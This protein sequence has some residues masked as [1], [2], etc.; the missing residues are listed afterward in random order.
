ML[1]PDPSTVSDL[2]NLT[3]DKE[4][5][6]YF[7]IVV[8]LFCISLSL[9]LLLGYNNSEMSL[10]TKVEKIIVVVKTADH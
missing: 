2:E 8:W 7:H 4:V 9:S 1:Q 6:S 3:L 10:L 5:C